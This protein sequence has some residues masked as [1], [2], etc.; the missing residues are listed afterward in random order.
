ML[1]L[2]N[3]LNQDIQPNHSRTAMKTLFIASPRNWTADNKKK[4]LFSFFWEIAASTVNAFSSETSPELPHNSYISSCCVSTEAQKGKE[5]PD[6]STFS[7][8]NFIFF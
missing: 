4:Y 8:N 6:Q 7:I 2:C 5:P 3:Q 1:E